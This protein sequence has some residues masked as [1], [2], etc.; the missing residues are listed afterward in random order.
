MRIIV[1]IDGSEHAAAAAFLLGAQR[2]PLGTKIRLLTVV[3]SVYLADDYATHL[4]SPFHQ[5]L[6]ET[7][8]EALRVNLRSANLLRKTGASVKIAIRQGHP[9][10]EI[11]EDARGWRADVVVLG[12][13]GRSPGEEAALGSIAA[14]V[15]VHAPCSVE[16]VRTPAASGGD[17]SKQLSPHWLTAAGSAQMRPI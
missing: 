17:Q 7:D 4:S 12:S 1:A 2:W 13:R 16:V 3:D 8:K 14:Y 10:M 9:G 5:L 11:V 6:Q 15:L